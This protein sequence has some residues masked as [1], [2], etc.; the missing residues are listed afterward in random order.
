[1]AIAHSEDLI[2]EVI[3]IGTSSEISI[4]ELAR[5]I[6]RLMNKKIVL[7]EDKERIRPDESEVERLLCDNRKIVKST[8]WTP[9]FSLEQGLEE[10]IAW[11]K[12][13][14]RLY[15]SEIYNV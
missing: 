8:G 12:E 14:Q 2:G 9:Q 7:K 15:N 4:D 3:N 10:T 11:F 6:A 5:H 1:M 13:A